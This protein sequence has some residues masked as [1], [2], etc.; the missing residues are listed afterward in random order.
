MLA[1]RYRWEDEHEEPF[2]HDYVIFAYTDDKKEA[3]SFAKKIMH[4][5]EW[6]G[7]DVDI[8]ND[9]RYLVST[10]SY[11][12]LYEAVE[13]FFDIDVHVSDDRTASLFHD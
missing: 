6:D 10:P 8:D 13:T 4:E 12:L 3:I 7:E 5:Q 11:D 1:V 9:D 2:S